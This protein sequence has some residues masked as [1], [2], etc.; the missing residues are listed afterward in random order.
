MAYCG[1]CGTHVDDGARFCGLC[2]AGLSGPASVA[3]SYQKP[4][5]PEKKSKEDKILARKQKYRVADTGERFV[6]LIIDWIV[7][8]IIGSVIGLAVPPLPRIWGP[9][10]WGMNFVINGAVGFFYFFLLEGYNHGKTVGKAVMG[11]KSVRGKNWKSVKPKE[12]IVNALGKSYFLVLDVLIGLIT[13]SD[14]DE[15]NQVRALQ[16]A[17]DVVVVREASR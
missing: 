6:A 9:L 10:S 1:N 16:R 4:G 7:I 14:N 3:G 5:K 11:M 2:G 12:A 17:T 8:G 13:R 15:K